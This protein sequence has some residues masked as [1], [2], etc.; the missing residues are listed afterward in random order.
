MGI[1]LG[2]R[3]ANSNAPSTKPIL[4]RSLCGENQEA[5]KARDETDG[6]GQRLVFVGVKILQSIVS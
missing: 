3:M 6:Y 2:Y 1:R 4:R 5:N